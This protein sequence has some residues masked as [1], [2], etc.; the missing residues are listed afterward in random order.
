M[1]ALRICVVSETRVHREALSKILSHWEAVDWTGH[2]GSLA[3]VAGHLE[4]PCPDV[5][6]IDVTT[7]DGATVREAQE[8]AAHPRLIA[9]GV[10]DQDVDFSPWIEAG[11][12]GYVPREASFHELVNAIRAVSTGEAWLPRRIGARLIEDVTAMARGHGHGASAAQLTTRELQVL[13]LVAEGLA[14]K[15]IAA[16]LYIELSTV[17]NH[18]HS[19]LIKL[20]AHTRTEAAAL[21]RR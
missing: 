7:V 9:V 14:N 17:K 16:N 2:A 8:R 3:E 6:L 4:R 13:K 10:P 1:Q 12:A 15:E 5:V 11:I 21:V 19:I 18:V 20:G